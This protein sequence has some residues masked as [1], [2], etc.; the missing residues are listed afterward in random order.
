MKNATVCRFQTRIQYHIIVAV[1]ARYCLIR[2]VYCRRNC[3]FI[4][5]GKMPGETVIL[6][7][8]KTREN[9]RVLSEKQ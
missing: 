4:C 7:F 9:V 8:V 2:I 6:V 3:S 5:P 1:I